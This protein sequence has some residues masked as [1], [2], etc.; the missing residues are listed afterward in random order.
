MSIFIISQTHFSLALECKIPSGVLMSST[1]LQ[2][3]LGLAATRLHH[4]GDGTSVHTDRDSIPGL[5]E[6]LDGFRM[7]GTCPHHTLPAGFSR[8]ALARAEEDDR[9]L[10][11]TWTPEALFPP[12]QAHGWLHGV[13]CG[14]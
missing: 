4:G 1:S 9:D 2:D 14:L 11:L 7:G 13:T 10:V 8:P 6:L 12:S 5:L 3:S